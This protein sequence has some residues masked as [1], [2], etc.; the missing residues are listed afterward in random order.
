MLAVGSHDNNIYLYDTKDY[1]LLGKT[2]AH[3][4][5]IVAIDWSL[6]GSY[7]RSVC[8]AH[9]LLFF[10][11]NKLDQDPSGAS[12][13]TSTQ[14]ATHH[15]KFGWS[16]DGIFPSG[17]DG[18]HINSVDF[19]KDESLIATADDYGLINI[20]RNPARPGSTPISLRGHS[21]HVVRVLFNKRDNYL[22]SIG[23]FDQTLMQWKR[24]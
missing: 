12:N 18:T 13:T 7:L 16:V 21:E 8:G 15:V 23:G 10:R 4:S 3:K 2:N 6:D 9:E 11:T 20:F 22:F 5:F 24:A 19:S 17:T 1:S 14:W